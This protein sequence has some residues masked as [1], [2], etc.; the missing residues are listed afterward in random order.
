LNPIQTASGKRD[1]SRCPTD[2]IRFNPKDVDAAKLLKS[3]SD[4]ALKELKIDIS[5]TLE[6]N[7]SVKPGIPEIWIYK[8]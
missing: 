4:E 6:P 5:L 8:R 7:A 3:D 1:F 2:K